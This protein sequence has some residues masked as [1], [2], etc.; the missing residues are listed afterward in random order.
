MDLSGKVAVVT[1]ASRGLGVGVAEAALDA[2]MSV[3]VCSRSKPALSQSPRLA[4]LELDVSKAADVDRLA[5]ETV[6]RF[7]QID[8]WVNNAGVLDPVG[9][10]RSAD[11]T[12]LA[13]HFEVNVLGVVLGSRA[14][15]R[16]LHETDRRGVLLNI[17]SGAARKPYVGWAPYCAGKAAIDGLSEVIAL[18]EGDRVRVHAV[19]PGV[20][21]SPMQAQVRTHDPAWFPALSKFTETHA[22]GGLVA[23]R[24][25]GEALLALAFDPTAARSEVCMDLRD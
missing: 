2:G 18:E 1:G 13:R 12:E 9:P 22:A 16:V 3:V 6:A 5:Q 7:G 23:P 25:A 17:S 10:L 11:P 15:L 14:F 24:V 20:I 19:A 4:A 8:L 21:D